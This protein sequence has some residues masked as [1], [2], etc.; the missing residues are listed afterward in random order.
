MKRIEL[1]RLIKEV[2]QEV[3]ATAEE[4][5]AN[6]VISNWKETLGTTKVYNIEISSDSRTLTIKLI[7]GGTAQISSQTPLILKPFNHVNESRKKEF[8]R[9]WVKPGCKYCEEHKFDRDMPAHEPSSAC[10]SGKK[11]HCTCDACY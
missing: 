1:K 11:P 7:D 8:N 5:V 6:S 3:S 9:K 10:E 4:N 2:I